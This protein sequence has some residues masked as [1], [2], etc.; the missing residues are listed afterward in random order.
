MNLLK[1]LF[2]ATALSTGTMAF[3]DAESMKEAE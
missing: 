3:A 1:N 2:L